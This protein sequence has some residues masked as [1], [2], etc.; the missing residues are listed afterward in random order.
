MALT[1]LPLLAA[2][3]LVVP[4][5]AQPSLDPP[6]PG[7]GQPGA[8]RFDAYPLPESLA[9][10]ASSGEPSI[11]I[12]WNTDHAFFQAYTS[13]H[14]A[15]FTDPPGGAR[16]T[17]EWS[18]VTPPFSLHNVDP[19]L[20]ADPAAN[21]VYAGGLN[22]PC[23]VM[24][25]SDDDGATWLPSRNMCTGAQF[26]HQSLGAGP[27]PPGHALGR[28]GARAVYYCAQLVLDACATS[29][30]GG[31]TWL[32][33]VEVLGAC[34]G[35]HG[36]VKVGPTGFAVLPAKDCG[37]KVGFGYTADGGL[38]WNSRVMPDAEA[39]D[40]FDPSAAFSR[41]GWLWLAQAAENG[42]HVA[43]SKD[44][45]VT[46]ETL[47]TATPGAR[48]AKWLDLA[49]LHADPWTGHPLRFG[50]FA[51]VAAGD[52]ERVA[53]TFLATTDP[54]GQHPFDDCGAASNRNLWHYYLA[55]S[56][57]GGASWAVERLT[58][59][60]VQV[61]AIW[62][63]G[64]SARCR[65]L[66]DFADMAI[67]SKGRVH[68][69]F[70]DGC[71]KQCAAKYADYVNG[72]GP[73]PKG[74]HSRDAR[75]TILRQATGLGLL[76]KE[77]A[78]LTAAPAQE[79]APTVRQAP[80]LPGL[81]VAAA[82]AL[83][84]LA[85]RARAGNTRRSHRS[86]RLLIASRSPLLPMRSL[87]ALATFAALL[88]AGC[89]QPPDPA[90]DCLEASAGCATA[91]T[92]ASCT[93]TTSTAAPGAANAKGA[94]TDSTLYSFAGVVTGANPPHPV[95]EGPLAPEPVP[96]A[97]RDTFQVPAGTVGLSFSSTVGP[98][99]GKGEV[100]IYAPDGKIVYQSGDGICAGAPGG[101]AVCANAPST[102]TLAQAPAGEYTIAYCIAGTMDVVLEVEATITAA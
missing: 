102:T 61:G 10:A 58:H 98:G 94:T 18:D 71:T 74:T 33:P 63:L 64:G 96:V 85:A 48:P 43:L 57:D 93:S 11:G 69:A 45:G 31:F 4:A 23:S 54:R 49:P 76:A 56:F 68:V 7:F 6:S 66:L 92:D 38:T 89:A 79:G 37:G 30:D 44:D 90:T 3:L 83:A 47:G 82:V 16:A 24:G 81:A 13:T 75:G 65:N 19:L 51:N 77:D 27:W 29:L 17:V 42:V 8:P 2:L 5:A 78:N 72:T 21:R 9:N 67:D 53:F 20:Y 84:L 91:C 40:G 14:R 36:H 41:S 22:G 34:A 100:F 50:A 62:N 46:W 39:G 101:P 70:A 87:C 73:S 97:K 35:L 59:D 86:A 80:A 32:P 99:T 60:P 88:L 1:R 15:V 26:D 95:S 25:I 55:A 28:E 52:D 12:P